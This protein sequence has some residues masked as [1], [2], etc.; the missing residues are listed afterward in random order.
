MHVT[1]SHFFF[2]STP[3]DFTG[4]ISPG[5][6][7]DYADLTIGGGIDGPAK[8]FIASVRVI[9]KQDLIARLEFYRRTQSKVVNTASF[10]PSSLIGWVDLL[11]SNSGVPANWPAGR[12][13]VATTY[14]TMFAWFLEGITIPYED[15][16]PGTG[17]LHINYVNLSDAAKS[18]GTA[19][20]LNIQVGTINAS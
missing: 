13:A 12:F 14:G 8:S 17:Q 19:G 2:E 9:A 3:S 5:G 1:S 10:F 15:L 11:D 4:A 16:D 18:A 6:A 20:Y 7:S